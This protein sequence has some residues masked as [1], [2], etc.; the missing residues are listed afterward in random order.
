MIAGG[1][2]VAEPVWTPPSPAGNDVTHGVVVHPDFATNRLVYVS[3]M[4]GDDTRQTLAISRGRLD[5]ATG[6]L[7]DVREIFVAEAW[8][9]ARMAFNGR[10]EFGPD[11]T[12]Y[13][14]VGDRDR[15]CCGQ[16]DDTSIRMRAQIAG[17]PRRQ[18][19]AL[20][21]RRHG[22]RRQSVRRPRRRASPRFSPTA[23]ATASA[24]ASTPRPA[25]SGRWKS[26]PWAATRS[27]S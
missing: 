9:N 10:M 24:C 21:G 3:Y 27:T 19:P 16:Q 6:K 11:K 15:L 13:V 12:L 18:G 20:E 5:A 1:K 7:V 17:R 14:T 25:S 26:A 22:A 2:L 8:E 4:K 23:T